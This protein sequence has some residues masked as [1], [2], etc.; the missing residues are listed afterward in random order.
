MG[1]MRAHMIVGTLGGWWCGE[2]DGRKYGPTLEVDQWDE[3]LRDA[4]F[5]GIQVSFSDAP[6]P[7]TAVSVIGTG[8]AGTAEPSVPKEVLLVAPN[9][10][11][12][13]VA[14]A[15]IALER[16]L[17]ERGATVTTVSLTETAALDASKLKRMS[18][19][20]LVDARTA[21][22]ILPS[23]GQEEW[24]ALKHLIMSIG[25]MTYVT[26]DAT[27]DSENPS[28]N[29]MTGMARTIRSE[30]DE[31]RLTT[32]DMESTSSLSSRDNI[33]A[34]LK[35]FICASQPLDNERRP[36][37]EYAVRQ[38]KHMV[39]RIIVES[40]VN[41]MAS[42]WYG[43]PKPELLP[44]KQ[45][46]RRLKLGIENPGRLDT[47]RFDDDQVMNKELGA[48]E[49]E[50]EVKAM[51][52]NFKDIMVAMGQLSQP[53]LGLECSGFISRV[54]SAVKGFAP[55]DA[56]LTWK[57]DTYNSFTRAPAAMVQHIP[58][59]MSVVEAASIPFIYCTV[60]RAL[61]GAA[62]FRKG[63]S[64]LIHGAAGGVG[65]AAII[66]AQA[67]G[68]TVFATVSTNAKKKHLMEAYGLPESHIFNSRDSLQFSQA[69]LR[70]TNERGVDVVLNS[71]AGEALRASWRVIARFG[72]FVEL[73]QRDIVG[74]TGL[75]MEPFFRNV[76][77]HSVNLTDF[78]EHDI[79]GAAQDLAKVVEM[80]NQRV[81][82]PVSPINTFPL[83]RIEEA[84]R[85]MQTGAHMGK[86][87]LE[88]NDND[89]VPM[90][91]A[92]APPVRFSKDGT[93]VISGGSGGLGRF[94]A[95]WMVKSG[96]RNIIILSRSGDAKPAVRDLVANLEG[97]G[98]R[99][100]A[101]ACDVG[102]ELAVRQAAER[103]Q[104]E[105]WPQIRG[106]I[107]GAMTLQDAVSIIPLVYA[108]YET[109]C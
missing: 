24:D 11:D 15:A 89:L 73:G 86:I 42:A 69:V 98:A 75:D 59:G 20:C 64:I 88:V 53:A 105:S 104:K 16:E 87:I 70:L 56:V 80:L 31:V 97:A 77:F 27:Q 60:Y 23:I 106:I 22:G 57:L 66:M 48:D 62:R 7:D 72:R 82:K 65:Q 34:L 26:R 107:Q 90:L 12:H 29:L 102:D 4:G 109:A 45:P 46:G 85:I 79:D 37:W 54:G 91:P 61:E 100:A 108:V 68:A 1:K 19:I 93:Y 2:Q 52:L 67:I 95:T 17:I 14:Q 33:A 103:C 41:E 21:E 83:S 30:L 76:S 18:C 6:S 99:A 50:I 36:D 71:L 47:L 9:T 43:P 25:S 39:Q 3:D 84:F 28:N 74:N 63:E 44:F 35:V 92:K 81:I 94:T 38:G 101:W 32:V 51:G 49:I 55:G 10:L 13:D 58:Q 96:A 40:N 5:D 8:I 78:L